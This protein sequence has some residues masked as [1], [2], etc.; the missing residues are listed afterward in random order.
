[1]KRKV[2]SFWSQY[3]RI[4]HKIQFFPHTYNAFICFMFLM[5]GSLSSSAQKSKTPV[6]KVLDIGSQR[7]LFVDDV[8]VNRFFGK[9][10]LRLHH[11]VIQEIALLTDEP[12]KG[13]SVIIIAFS[14]MGISTAC[15]IEDG[16]GA[17]TG[18]LLIRWFG[19]MRKVKMGYIG[20]NLIWVCS[21]LMV[22]S[23]TTLY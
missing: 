5:A 8:L 10:E 6:A 17:P 12:W 14:R 20:R 2:C 16:T 23:I 9:A 7:Q 13:A 22:R 18:K 21:N 1:M 4:N 15:I 11:P 3:I 19:V